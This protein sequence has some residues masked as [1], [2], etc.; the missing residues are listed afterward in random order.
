METVVVVQKYII[1]NYIKTAGPVSIYNIIQKQYKD[2]A[3]SQ[4]P[5]YSWHGAGTIWVI[6]WGAL[7]FKNSFFA[8]FQSPVFNFFLFTNLGCTR[9][10]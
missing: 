3:A 4:R 10:G 2:W 7:K 5:V 1:K 6:F 8:G 9:Q